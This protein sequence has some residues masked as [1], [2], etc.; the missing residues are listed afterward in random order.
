MLRVYV[1]RMENFLLT[2]IGCLYI[3]QNLEMKIFNMTLIRI[4]KEL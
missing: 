2:T 3:L 1:T 4:S